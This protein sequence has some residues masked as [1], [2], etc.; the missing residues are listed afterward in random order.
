MKR[1]FLFAAGIALT[2][3]LFAAEDG[4]RIVDDAWLKAITANDLDAVVALYADDATFCLDGVAS[5]GKEAIRKAYTD[6]LGPNEVKDVKLTERHYR[7]AGDQSASWGKATMTLAPKAGGGTPATIEVFYTSL[8]VKHG[9]RWVYLV[10]HASAP[11][12][13]AAEKK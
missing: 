9:G 3:V 13:P 12:P 6:M 1:M 4:G 5:M 8:S 11:P 7:S 2:A 10:D